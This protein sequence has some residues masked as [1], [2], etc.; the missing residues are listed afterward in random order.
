MVLLEVIPISTIETK[1]PKTKNT[2]K[3]IKAKISTNELAKPENI[4][5]PVKSIT[6]RRKLRSNQNPELVPIDSNINSNKGEAGE[7]FVV[8]K[9]FH[10]GK[11]EN[12]D[13]REKLV[14]LL[15]S[16]ASDGI[17][18]L[19]IYEKTPVKSKKKSAKTEDVSDSNSCDESVN[20]D[21]S[22]TSVILDYTLLKEVID[23]S[24]ITKAKSSS[25][26]DCIIKFKSNG[27]IC[28]ISIKCMHGGKPSILNHTP[29]SAPVFQSGKLKDELGN[30]DILIK[31]LNKEREEG[32]V[33]EE[34]NISKVFPNLKPELKDSLVK[35]IGY[36]MFEGTGSSLSS[37]PANSIL[38]IGIPSE[39]NTWEFL[40]CELEIEKNMYINS[41]YS[42]I[43]VSLVNKN[44]PAKYKSV[45]AECVP[46]IFYDAKSKKEKGCLHIRLSK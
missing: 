29:R 9:L 44:M 38:K 5:S 30:L 31:M 21:I 20:S 2:R 7:T 46:W 25:K 3:S 6:P 24:E 1:P 18:L 11:S 22:E 39:M 28:G 8:R 33:N 10:M 19:N 34:I 45:Y 27:K 13:D 36:F 41:L 32:N 14:N 4:E 37:N 16:D 43:Y 35:T 23:E 26:A 17:S 15:G 40:S 42:K 12:K